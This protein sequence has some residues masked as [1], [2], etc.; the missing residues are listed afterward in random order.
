MA[1]A[2]GPPD[3]EHQL[4]G[5]GDLRRELGQTGT[6]HGHDNRPTTAS[7]APGTATTLVSMRRPV[8]TSC[9]RSSSGPSRPGPSGSSTRPATPSCR[10]SCRHAPARGRD[11]R[12]SDDASSAFRRCARRRRAARAVGSRRS[13]GLPGPHVRGRPLRARPAARPSRQKDR[14]LEAEVSPRC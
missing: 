6:G 3:G 10:A 13:S 9:D 8:T 4:A 5:E 11:A 1:G 14:E 2:G 12:L 7:R